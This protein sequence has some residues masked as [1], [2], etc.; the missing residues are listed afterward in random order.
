MLGDQV[1]EKCGQLI[2]RGTAECPLCSNPLG[3]SLRRETVLLLSIV[4]LAILFGI[5][6]VLVKQ[7]HARERALGREWYERG[8]QQMDRK[9]SVGAITAFRTAIF[10][11]PN[12]PT[13]QLRLAQSLVD[14]GRLTEARTYLLRLWQTNP[15]NGA[16]N[17]ELARVAMRTNDVPSVIRYYH[18]AIAGEWPPQSPNHPRVL[19]EQLCEYLISHNH[20]EEA[21]AELVAL[22]RETPQNARLRTQVAEL[23]LEAQDYDIAYQQFRRSLRL[24][25]KQQ[26]AWAGAGKAAFMMGDY[27]T[28]RDNLTRAVM[29][30][31][32]DA[33]SSSL[34]RTANQVIAIN[35]FDPRVPSSMRYKR[36]IEDFGI[37][38]RRL[39][40]CAA[41]KG[42]TLKPAA[43]PQTALQRLHAVAMSMQP[44]V[45][46]EKMRRDPDLLDS[47]MSLAFEI[48]QAAT[49][50]CGPP[51][52]LDR[53][54][55]LVGSKTEG[56]GE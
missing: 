50:E 48:E 49:S 18:S 17:L 33:E 38:M 3:F 15:A 52:G 21:L 32:H 9:Q 35:P 28:A 26:V 5:T 31:P 7:Y 54:L 19:R 12:N 41:S 36:A 47:T 39:E 14:S 20:R 13:Y 43:N 23:F 37:A 8:E 30:N 45:T 29:L 44:D 25:R 27:Q 24:D 22:A 4:V 6:G 10:H 46:L 55:S 34:L 42:Q 2:P 56:A 40:S 16:V 51:Q 1:C 11:V 53:A